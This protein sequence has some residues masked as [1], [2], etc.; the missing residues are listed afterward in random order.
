MILVNVPHIAG[1]L[2]LYFA[3]S[4]TDLYIAGKFDFSC[5]TLSQLNIS[6]FSN[7]AVLLGLGVG[8]Y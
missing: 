6:S 4:L 2:L 1:W 8:Q 3:S 7:A 5:Q